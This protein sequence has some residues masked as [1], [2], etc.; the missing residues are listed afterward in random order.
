MNFVCPHCN[1]NAFLLTTDSVGRTIVTCIKCKI[2]LPF[3]A[4]TKTR[5]HF[6]IGRDYAQQETT[7][8]AARSA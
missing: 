6:R 7:Q 5:P 3:D 1:L 4:F 8:L 2:P